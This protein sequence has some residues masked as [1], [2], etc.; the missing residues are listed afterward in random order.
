MKHPMQAIILKDG[1]ARFQSNAII[2]HLFDTGAID[3]NKLATMGFSK[4][5]H[6][7]LAQLMGYSVSGFGDLSYADPLVVRVA[8]EIVE[9]IFKP[10][11]KTMAEPNSPRE[12]VEQHRT[13]QAAQ[14]LA[15][16]QAKHAA[17]FKAGDVVVLK[18]GGP[19]M[20]VW[21]INPDGVVNVNWF[22]GGELKSGGFGDIELDPAPSAT[23]SG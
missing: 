3:L 10:K 17:R 7:Q 23:P 18:S 2:E 9:K 8:D 21:G 12:V 5:D 13:Q 6:M 14:G 1:V 4:E 15:E 22:D 16:A 11:E 19:K 20:T